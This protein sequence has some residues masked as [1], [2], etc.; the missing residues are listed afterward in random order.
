MIK[1]KIFDDV[2]ILKNKKFFDQ[3]GYLDILDF[4]KNRFLDKKYN[5]IISLNKYKGTI[6]GLHYQK[7]EPH[8]KIIK[9][10]K[11]RIFDVFI[12]INPNSKN[13]LKYKY[14]YLDAEKI[15]T[16]YIGK[17]YAH[18]YQTQ[19]KDTLI[20]YYI[21]GRLLP[22][23]SETIVYNDPGLAIPWP[24]KCSKISSKDLSGKKI[25]SLL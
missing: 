11:G 1:K 6:R 24:M 3:R 8:A 17:D 14:C 23:L 25:G 21:N 18:G 4:K 5:S 20:I 7:K 9:V 12:N 10:I 16:L 22:K 15:N 13:F 2:F 19:V